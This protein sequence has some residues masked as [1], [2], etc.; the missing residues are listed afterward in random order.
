MGGELGAEI[1]AEVLRIY[2]QRCMSKVQGYEWRQMVLSGHT[3][4]AGQPHSRGPSDSISAIE[5][6]Q[7]IFT[8][9]PR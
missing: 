4:L 5:N 2:G 3:D 1:V 6:I 8:S 7:C 9:V